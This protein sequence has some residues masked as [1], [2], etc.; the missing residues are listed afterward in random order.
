MSQGSELRWESNVWGFNNRLLYEF[1]LVEEHQLVPEVVVT[2]QECQESSC[3]TVETS[4]DTSVLVAEQGAEL[5]AV[6][7]FDEAQRRLSCNA[8]GQGRGSL[9]WTTSPDTGWDTGTTYEKTIPWGLVFDELHVQ[10][11]ECSG[12]DCSVATWSTTVALEPR[13]DC[14]EDFAGWFTTFP[15]EDYTLIYEVGPPG[16]IDPDDHR[17]HGYFRVPDGMNVVDIRMPVDATLYGGSNSI[18]WSQRTWGELEIQYRLDFHTKCEGIKLRLDH[19][20]EPVP[21][22]AALF[23]QEPLVND[24]RGVYFTPVEVKEGDLVAT[25]IGF[26]TTGNAFLDFGVYDD[27]KRVQTALD[28]RFLNAA[29]FY[30]FFSP[31]LAD[32]L[33]ARITRVDNLAD[34]L[35]P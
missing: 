14:P 25:S 8:S 22:I 23:T 34:E 35:C 28:P 6:C 16:R 33:S 17:G 31:A 12:S 19:V 26:E 10:L 3:Q 15:L 32:Y 30:E 21:E 29:C 1:E 20:R 18:R 2:L 4:I 13:G 11:E 9:T 5:T 27:F 7:S 24:T